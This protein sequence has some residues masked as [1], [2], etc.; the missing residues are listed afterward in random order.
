MGKPWVDGRT[1]RVMVDELARVYG[2]RCWLCGGVIDPSLDRRR[3]GGATIDHVLPRLHGGSD[4]LENLRLAHKG[5]NSTK[6]ARGA[7]R[8]RHIVDSPI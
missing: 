5:C 1:I 6:G 3:R 4:S 2:W 8:V 7:W